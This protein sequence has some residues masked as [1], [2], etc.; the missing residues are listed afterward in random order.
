MDATS[1]LIVH[2]KPGIENVLERF[3]I[4]KKSEECSFSHGLGGLCKAFR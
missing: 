4:G 3:S 1:G 2:Y